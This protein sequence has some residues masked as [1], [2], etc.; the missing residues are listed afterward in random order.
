MDFVERVLVLRGP[1]NIEKF[2]LSCEAK[3][4]Q[5]RIGTWISAAVNRNVKDVYLVL[6]DIESSFVFPRCLFNCETLTEF[7]L[8]M[9]FI[10][11][12]PSSISLPCLKILNLRQVTFIDDQSTQQLFSLPNLVELEI[13]ECNWKNLVWVTICAPKLQ[14]LAI[15]E[16]HESTPANSGGCHVRIFRT[17]L[18]DFSFCGTLS[19]EFCLDESSVVETFITLIS[20]SD[21][22]R[23]TAC[24]SYKLLEGISS[25]E[26]LYLT[27]DVVDVLDHAS[28]LLAFPLEFRNLTSLIFESDRVELS[29][30]PS[31][32]RED[33]TLDPA[34]L[35]FLSCLHFIEVFN[36]LGGEEAIDA[37][38][39]LLKN[40]TALHQMSIC[41]AGPGVMTNKIRRQL[42]DLPG[43]SKIGKINSGVPLSSPPPLMA[44]PSDLTNPEA[45]AAI[46]K[47]KSGPQ[48]KFLVPL[49]YA[50]VL[51][52]I[53]LT[54]R[55]N[56]VVRDRLFTA[57][58]V[59][60]FAHGF[61]LVLIWGGYNRESDIGGW[62]LQMFKPK[63]SQ[64]CVIS[65]QED[66][67][68]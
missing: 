52:L 6:S 54:L 31:N 20:D 38:G 28:D 57:V 30:V 1:S 41:W 11:K 19:N 43:W 68:A 32:C 56:P 50:P 58:L 49:V 23:E 4:D 45:A 13:Y 62:L 24:R 15:D 21:R 7:E 9:L 63:N 67:L 34:P 3:D 40:A 37:V 66:M 33:G 36:F 65:E 27:I 64:E 2:G 55:K 12:L 51:P 39:F 29:E 59:G 18:A 16:S 26:T 35:C 10:L 25:V 46:R 48:F 8:D 42:L 53:R 44:S 47:K 17:H 5:S 14:R 60:A 22:P 61:Y